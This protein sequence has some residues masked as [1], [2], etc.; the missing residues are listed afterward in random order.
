[1]F[2]VNRKV[3]IGIQKCKQ[4]MML[5]K[6]KKIYEMQTMKRVVSVF[7][8]FMFIKHYNCLSGSWSATSTIE[9]S[10]YYSL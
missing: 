8:V 10:S 6:N 5:R 1:M 2:S 3:Q 7:S 4:L 9:L